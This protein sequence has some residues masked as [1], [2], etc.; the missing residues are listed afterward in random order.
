MRQFNHTKLKDQKGN[1]V[2][3]KKQKKKELLV[4]FSRFSRSF[5]RMIRSLSKAVH[6]T[7]LRQS[8]WVVPARTCS[9]KKVDETAW[10]IWRMVITKKKKKKT[11]LERGETER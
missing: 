11:L 4:V 10:L 1:K 9:I 6:I 8:S 3:K 5:R 2:E 7:S